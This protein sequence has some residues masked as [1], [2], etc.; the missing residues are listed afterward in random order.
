MKLD[1]Q[2]IDSYF[3]NVILNMFRQNNGSMKNISRKTFLEFSAIDCSCGN[4]D[5]ERARLSMVESRNY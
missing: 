2:S 5:D 4:V 1:I 3:Y